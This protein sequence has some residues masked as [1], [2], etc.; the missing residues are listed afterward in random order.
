MS[1]FEIIKL[2]IVCYHA[3]IIVEPTC[4]DQDI[5]VTSSIQCICIV[6]VCLHASDLS[7]P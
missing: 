2:T 1:V 7:G 5:V 4:G 6:R 3:C